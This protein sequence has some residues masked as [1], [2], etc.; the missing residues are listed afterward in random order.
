M[1]SCLK[2]KSQSIIATKIKRKAMMY[3]LCPFIYRSPNSGT[4]NHEKLMVLLE[5]ISEYGSE[6]IVPDSAEFAEYKMGKPNMQI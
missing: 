1:W 4:K 6:H 5:E 3:S 2:R